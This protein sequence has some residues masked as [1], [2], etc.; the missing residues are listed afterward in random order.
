MDSLRYTPKHSI[1]P[2]AREVHFHAETGE[3]KD[4]G[5]RFLNKIVRAF[6]GREPS[7]GH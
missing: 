6:T 1:L 5:I 2:F 7:G 4:G 3:W